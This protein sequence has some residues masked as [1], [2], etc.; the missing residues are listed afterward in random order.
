MSYRKF[1]AYIQIGTLLSSSLISK[2]SEGSNDKIY[3]Y[4]LSYDCALLFYSVL[5]KDDSEILG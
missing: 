5:W 1:I 2:V 3:I 4:I